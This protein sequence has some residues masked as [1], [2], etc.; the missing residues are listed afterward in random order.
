MRCSVCTNSLTDEQA[1]RKATVCSEDCRMTRNRYMR[2]FKDDRQCRVC[3]KPSTTTQRRSYSRFQLWEVEHPDLAFPK[4]WEVLSQ[5]G[6]T[7]EV[8]SK[9]IR[10]A[11]LQDFSFEYHPAAL[12]WTRFPKAGE[13]HGAMDQCVAVMREYW[14]ERESEQA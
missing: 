10:E 9:A 4:P 8:F 3:H 11:Q 14:A 2:K 5:R 6:I 12:K 13:E 1:K 7:L